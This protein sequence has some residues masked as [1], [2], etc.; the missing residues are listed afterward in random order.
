GSVTMS[1]Q[2]PGIGEWYRISGGAIFEVVAVDEE[3]GTVEVQYFDGTVEEIDLVEWHAQRSRGDIENVEAPE[4]PSG[5]FDQD[6]DDDEQPG[7]ATDRDN[8]RRSMSTL[9]GLDL[10]E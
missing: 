8:D 5:S 6:N 9:D 10:F 7:I 1:V 3:D 2:Q 4:D